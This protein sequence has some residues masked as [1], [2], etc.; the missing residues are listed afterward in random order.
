VD[1]TDFDAVR[2]VAEL[3]QAEHGGVDVLVNNAGS[4]RW[5]AIDETDPA[6]ALQMTLMPYLAAFALTHYLLKGMIARRSGMVVTVTSPA[7]IAPF[8]GAA[9]YSVARAAMRELSRSLRAD[10]RGTGVRA[11]LVMAGEVESE[12]WEHNPGARDRVPGVSR[13][14]GT[15]SPDDVA[16]AIVR[17]VEHDR[18]GATI[19]WRLAVIKATHSLLPDLVEE[20]VN[21]TGWRRS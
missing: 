14:I 20:V 3:I 13:L 11:A 21:R 2:E 7:A 9:A 8:P 15:L 6:Q 18:R 17:V 10:L 1:L 12:Y 5:L 4:G 19:P 16:G